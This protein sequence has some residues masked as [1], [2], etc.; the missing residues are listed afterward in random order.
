MYHFR[1]D[2]NEEMIFTDV[3]PKSVY[4][5]SSEGKT[6][7]RSENIRNKF[8][9]WEESAVEV[10]IDNLKELK[11]K[12]NEKA[13][14][15]FCV[16]EGIALNNHIIVN[17][18]GLQDMLDKYENQKGQS[19]FF[20]IDMEHCRACMVP[21]YHR[22]SHRELDTHHKNKKYLQL[23]K[24][25]YGSYDVGI[26]VLS[27]TQIQTQETEMDTNCPNDPG[28]IVNRH[29][30]TS[31]VIEKPE[32]SFTDI[33]LCNISD[34]PVK[35]TKVIV[36]NAAYGNI[37]V[38]DKNGE[39]VGTNTVFDLKQPELLV[40]SSPNEQPSSGPKQVPPPN[41]MSKAI[42]IYCSKETSS[43]DI[44][45]DVFYLESGLEKTT[46]V[47]FQVKKNYSFR[48]F[49]IETTKRDYSKFKHDKTAIDADFEPYN[50][51][52]ESINEEFLGKNWYLSYEYLDFALDKDNENSLVGKPKEILECLKEKTTSKNYVEK[53]IHHTKCELLN[54]YENQFSSRAPVI[55]IE[56]NNVGD[57]LTLDTQ[58]LTAS[59]MGLKPG[60]KL[61]VLLDNTVCKQ[62]IIEI[63]DTDVL[64]VQMSDTNF[65]ET[66][67]CVGISN[68]IRTQPFHILLR[69]LSA[70]KDNRIKE[71]VD[72]FFTPEEFE[73]PTVKELD[74]GDINFVN[75]NMD[76]NQKDVVINILRL[77]DGS[78]YILFG[79]PGTGKTTTGIEVVI[80]EYLRG[81]T[82][83]IVAPTNSAANNFYIL[84]KKTEALKDAKIVK[85]VSSNCPV[86]QDCHTYC[87]ENLNETQT[88][89]LFPKQSV[90]RD[91]NIVV[92]TTYTSIR[93]FNL[94]D[95]ENTWNKKVDL[96]VADETP[97]GNEANLLM[98]IMSQVLAG[99]TKFR[100]VTMG[101]PQQ[102]KMT[103]R[104]VAGRLSD[105]RDFMTRLEESDL[106]KGN[107]SL[108]AHLTKNF[109][110]GE[111]IVHPINLM[112]Y[113]HNPQTPTLGVTGKISFHH[114]ETSYSDIANVSKYSIPE[115]LKVLDIVLE[116]RLSKRPGKVI[117]STYY[118]GNCDVIGI[119]AKSRRQFGVKYSTAEG[120]QGLECKDIVISTCMPTVNNKWHNNA[121]RLNVMMT[122]ATDNIII[123]GDLFKLSQNRL[124]RPL[125]MTSLTEENVYASPITLERLKLFMG[126]RSK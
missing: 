42:Q 38:T 87:A 58:I 63:I 116:K 103:S 9:N 115:T 97:F 11:V 31:L 27:I 32:E 93:L 22:T 95:G 30:V 75:K 25:N 34:K 120:L 2:I 62:G 69:C 19:L 126:R 61:L 96:I 90:L 80:Q 52:S 44:T 89:H 37:Y 36:D 124:Y 7:A 108:V 78:V 113:T 91:S 33:H 99:N 64:K 82:I 12:V 15:D 118:R 8:P 88:A 47:I 98:P 102:I 110:N 23:P 39:K 67:D 21:V 94:K 3:Y 72:R 43:Q 35:L 4:L 119:E 16:R 41:R 6:S 14:Y 84:L 1:T 24:L 73:Q 18:K 77:P 74:K 48:E 114:A 26:N 85:F 79:P 76:E 10:Y 106:Y 54:Y 101:D 111:Q 29:G 59:R 60:D 55:E 112:S 20:K 105:E 123:V 107:P 121:N 56:R 28:I 81:T 45:I 13:K 117:I 65:V 49:N 17:K 122:R 109:R 5:Y 86:T 53:I 51:K 125:L 40:K 71:A 70:L 92:S 100:L 50:K 46:K 68:T 57:T 66:G 104:S 83:L